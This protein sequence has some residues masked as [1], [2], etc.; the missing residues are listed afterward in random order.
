MAIDPATGK[1]YWADFGSGL[2]RTGNLNG[3]SASTVFKGEGGPLGLTIDAAAGKLYWSDDSSGLIRVGNLN[4]TG[5]RDL[6][7]GEMGPTG[8]A[9][10]PALGK[11]YA[12]SSIPSSPV[13]ATSLARPTTG[14][15]P[16]ETSGWWA[17]AAS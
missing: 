1:I 13:M 16:S 3:T 5:A 15:A 4:G 9:I 7:T 17:F 6:F 10:D 8:L 2:I 11:I 12:P 14:R